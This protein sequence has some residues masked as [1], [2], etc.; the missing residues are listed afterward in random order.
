[1]ALA[2]SQARLLALTA[3]KHDCEY[4]ETLQAARKISLAKESSDLQR[5]YL[6]RLQ[7]KNISYYANGKYNKINYNYI[8]GSSDFTQILDGSEHLK[9]NNSMILCDYKGQVVL[10]EEYAKAITTVCP[11]A[12][13]SDGKGKTFSSSNIAAMIA[14]LTSLD[15]EEIKKVINGENVEKTHTVDAQNDVTMENMGDAGTRD[16][17]DVYTSGIMSII[18]FYLPIFQAAATNGWTTEYNDSMRDNPDYLNDALNTGIFQLVSVYDDGNYD[19]NTS[20]DYF[21][22]KDAVEQSGDSEKREEIKAWYEEEKAILNEKET[23]IDL[24][25]NELSSEIEAI[26]AEMDSIQSL[27]QDSISSVFDWGSS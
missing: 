9:K 26:K 10:S 21:I 3:R 11:D 25:L 14:E 20:L 5:E 16:Y 7:A 22:L 6:S 12:L 2:A 23:E 18:D 27:I 4:A 24:K 15:V 17:S 1:M 13:G 8:M 19:P